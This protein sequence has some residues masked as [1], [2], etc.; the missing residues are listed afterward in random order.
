MSSHG[1][2]TEP[3]RGMN[4]DPRQALHEIPDLVN[5]QKRGEGTQGNQPGFR[6]PNS[7]LGS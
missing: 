3:T 5:F 7:Y 1:K 6:F 2:T 4:A